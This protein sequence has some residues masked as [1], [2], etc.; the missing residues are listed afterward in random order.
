[1]L[2]MEHIR[3]LIIETELLVR[4]HQRARHIHHLEME[5][6]I[7]LGHVTVVS[8]NL[9]ILVEHKSVLQVKMEIVQY[10][11]VMV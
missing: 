2:V 8:F 10:Q 9:E 3:L 4:M 1:M 11:M 5:L 7:V 6:I